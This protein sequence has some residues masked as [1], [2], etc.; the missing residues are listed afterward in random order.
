MARWLKAEANRV[1]GEIWEAEAQLQE[2]LRDAQRWAVLPVIQRCYTSLGLLAEARGD[3]AAAE[4]AFKQAIASIEDSRMPLP[5]EEFRV[6]YL[7]DKLTPYTELVRLCLADGSP[8]RVAEALGYVE[9]AR[10]RALVEMQGGVLPATFRPNDAF[11]AGLFEQREK[12]REELNWF[13]SQINRPDSA[14][15]SRGA[16]VMAMYY[17]AVREREARISEI[18]LQLRGRNAS[19]PIQADPFDLAQLQ[20]DL[21]SHTALIEYFSLDGALLAFLVTDEGIEVIHLPYTEEEAEAGLRLFHFQIG[22]LRHGAKHLRGHLPALVDRTRYHLSNLYDGLIR[23]F[24]GRLDGRRML[25]A[26]YRALHYVPFH[27][28]FDGSS[29]LIEHREVS[30][31]PSASVIRHSLAAPRRQI[32]RAALF[33]I[34]DERNPLVREEVLALAPLFPEAVTL[35]DEQA[36]RASLFEQSAKANLLHLACHGRFRPDNPLFSSLQLGD[37]WLT[38]RDA[39][40]LDLASELV[41]LSAC[42]TGVSALAP[43]DELIGLARGF[44]SAGAP[45]LLVSLW[46][47]DDEA[48][49]RLMTGFYSRLQANA[50]PA[51]AL[52]HAQCQLLVENPHPY[53]W[54]PFILLGRW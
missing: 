35:L 33:G 29:Y 19:V 37:G 30:Y 52:R 47:V 16:D 10:S 43:G 42:E 12:L 34:S 4:T 18:T 40:R 38:V 17:D 15:V 44:F 21:G 11:E 14:A 46:T 7:A 39:Y 50:G 25:V 32:E 9:R 23:P 24:A 31:T 3:A 13:Y 8:S 41:T 1:R 28:L 45:T 22:A 51:A 2:T 6:A 49:A 48:T 54:A 27:A 26:P 5:A 53:F 20:T 36:T